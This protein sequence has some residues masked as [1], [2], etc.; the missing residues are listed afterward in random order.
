MKVRSFALF[1]ELGFEYYLWWC[2]NCL[3]EEEERSTWLDIT[4]FDTK[5]EFRFKIEI[6]ERRNEERTSLKKHSLDNTLFIRE[7][8]VTTVQLAAAWQLKNKKGRP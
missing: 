8:V 7:F 2:W 1:V 6:S 4:G 3:Q 5:M